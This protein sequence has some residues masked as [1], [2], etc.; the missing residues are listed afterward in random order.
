MSDNNYYLHRPGF[1]PS[2]RA[3]YTIF[4]PSTNNFYTTM[5]VGRALLLNPGFSGNI[6]ILRNAA[7]IFESGDIENGSSVWLSVR[8]SQNFSH[9]FWNFD[10]WA[11]ILAYMILMDRPFHWYHIMTLTFDILQGY[12]PKFEQES[13]LLKI[14][15]TAFLFHT[16]PT[17][18][19]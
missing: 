10:E 6:C 13:Y 18:V 11:F 5:S 4:H 1:N 8:P 16:W 17:A 9:L 15:K 2:S 19:A 14:Y 3:T 12:F 7:T